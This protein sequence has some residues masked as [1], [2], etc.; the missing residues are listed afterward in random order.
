MATP[1]PIPVRAAPVIGPGS[2]PPED[3]A[4]LSFLPL[5]REMNTFEMPRVPEHVDP[6]LLTGVRDLIAQLVGALDAYDAV[7]DVGR[8][9]LELAGLP[10][11]LLKV[12]AEVLGEGEVSIKVRGLPE[13]RVQETVF[14]GLW[15]CCAIDAEQR[16]V[17]DWLE[18]GAVPHA[19]IDAAQAAAGAALAP[20]TLPEGTMNSPSLLAELAACLADVA[21]GRAARQI[22]LT[23]L[24]LAPEDR[25]VLESALPNGPVAMISRGFGNCHI[26]STLTRHVWRVQYFNTMKTLILD[27]IEVVDVPEAAT[28]SPEDLADTRERLAELAQWMTESAQEA[29]RDAAA[30]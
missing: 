23:L 14:A 26:T 22:N 28:A 20:V 6:S 17:R 25:S 29:A 9:V 3:D 15:R 13:L 11:P 19:V 7:N 8:P 27:T 30:R 4:D 18:A 16:V 10:A 2:Q 12:L 1:F 5:P 24:P 21:P